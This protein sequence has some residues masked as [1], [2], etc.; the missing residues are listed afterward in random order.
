[1]IVSVVSDQN[2]PIARRRPDP[3]AVRRT[4]RLDMF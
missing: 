2:A 3:T 1:L 4:A